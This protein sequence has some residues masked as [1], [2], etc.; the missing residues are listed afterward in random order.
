[1]PDKNGYI[2]P[3]P[4]AGTHRRQNG[5]R[6]G[7]SVILP[8]PCTHHPVSYTH[9][10]GHSRH[11]ISAM[12]QGKIDIGYSHHPF[13]HTGFQCDLVCEDEIILVTSKQPTDLNECITLK[14]METLRIYNSNFLYADTHNRIFSRY[15]AFQLD[16]DIGENIVPYLLND[17]GYAFVPR[18]MVEDVY[19]RQIMPTA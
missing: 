15:K 7:Q 18:K 12:H 13:R 6:E 10:F 3:S 2:V 9:L 5:G 8:A 11:I 17:D 19:K 1:M 16:I 4:H 14:D